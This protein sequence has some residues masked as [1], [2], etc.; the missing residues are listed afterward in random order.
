VTRFTTRAGYDGESLYVSD[1]ARYVREAGACR[2][3]PGGER[4]AILVSSEPLSDD[5]SWRAVPPCTMLSIDADGD[6]TETSLR[7][8]S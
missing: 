2:M 3:L 1:G 5:A 7:P 8:H 6:V 4:A